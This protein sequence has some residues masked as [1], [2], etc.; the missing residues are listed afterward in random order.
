MNTKQTKEYYYDQIIGLDRLPTLPLIATELGQ[1]TQEDNLSINQILPIVEKDPPFAMMVLKL[2]NS[3]YYG[4]NREI[5]SLHN[6]LVIIGLKELSELAIGFSV[7]RVMSPENE[8]G[9]IQWESLWEHSAGVGHVAQL[10]QKS[11]DIKIEGSP[12]ALGLLHDIGKIILYQLQPEKYMECLSYA[13]RERCTSYEAEEQ[14]LGIDHMTVGAMVAEKWKLPDPIVT[15]ISQH[16]HPGQSD[17]HDQNVITSLVHLSD[18]VC[19]ANFLSFGTDFIQFI[20]KDEISWTILK[21]VSPKIDD[22]DFE[23]F[24]MSIEDELA[25]IKSHVQLVAGK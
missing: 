13:A 14:V 4:I 6:A 25:T 24:V 17:D 1:I 16:H 15:A 23:R 11:L 10:L 2:A 12:Y 20:P 7:L 3:A 22:L 5:K 18:L 21:D 9:P 19:N 8:G